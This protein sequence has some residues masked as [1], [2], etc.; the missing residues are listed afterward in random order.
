MDTI[1]ENYQVL[2]DLVIFAYGLILCLN[3]LKFMHM[4][5]LIGNILLFTFRTSD[6]A[7]A[8]NSH[9]LYNGNM[10]NFEAPDATPIPQNENTDEKSLGYFKKLADSSDAEM[11]DVEERAK[12]IEKFQLTGDERAF[13]KLYKA[14][15]RLVFKV[16]DTYQKDNTALSVAQLIT[17]GARAL[18]GIFKNVDIKNHNANEQSAFI[19]NGIY[20]AITQDIRSG[21]D[22]A[23]KNARLEKVF[24]ENQ[25]YDVVQP[26]GPD[27]LDVIDPDAYNEQDFLE[28]REYIFGLIAGYPEFRK[29]GQALMKIDKKSIDIFIK[30]FHN[31]L[32][33]DKEDKRGNRSVVTQDDI[34]KKFDVSSSRVSKIIDDVRRKIK[35]RLIYGNDD[36]SANSEVFAKIEDRELP[37]ARARRPKPL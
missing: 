31:D 3:M 11:L 23:S 34:A 29:P 7:I 36:T 35:I 24:L 5:N 4:N 9:Y 26:N 37:H 18:P 14:Y 27:S 33:P 19:R 2:N 25:G 30:Y 6:S 8:D 32:F 13:N 16:A 20:A 15:S 21:K 12:L 10:K 28:L 22:L 1:K 17:A